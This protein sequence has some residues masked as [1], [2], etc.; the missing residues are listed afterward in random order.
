MKKVI[1]R[2]YC[3]AFVK[4]AMHADF[5][6]YV[7]LIPH[8]DIGT[9]PTSFIKEYLWRPDDASQLSLH[10]LYVRLL[11]NVVSKMLDQRSSIDP[12]DKIWKRDF[13]SA[14]NV[15]R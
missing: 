13:V 6:E 3:R 11:S 4:D 5:S 1:V 14:G 12:E 2:L 8:M 10:P 15:N 9:L 7:E